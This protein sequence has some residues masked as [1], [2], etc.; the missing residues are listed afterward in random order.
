MSLY[1]DVSIFLNKNF[2]LIIIPVKKD[3]DPVLVPCR[4]P[5]VYIP[6]CVE[7]MQSTTFVC[8]FVTCEVGVVKIV[9]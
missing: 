8:C 3:S 7:H 4:N 1:N 5:K 6:V 9:Q 2:C